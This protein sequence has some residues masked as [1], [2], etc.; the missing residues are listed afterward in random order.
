MSGSKHLISK[1]LSNILRQKFEVWEETEIIGG[2][3]L[4]YRPDAFFIAPEGTLFV[5]E[6]KINMVTIDHIRVL[7]DF[8]SDLQTV[9]GRAPIEIILCSPTPLSSNLKEY[10]DRASS[11]KFPIHF[12]LLTDKKA[13]YLL[14]LN[15]KSAEFK[16]ET[17]RVLSEILRG[18]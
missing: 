18:K 11:F 12:F 5:V 4:M 8:C 2:S 14:S 6:I 15:E 10:I 9:L 7:I 13:A 16:E 17:E 3:S 1:A